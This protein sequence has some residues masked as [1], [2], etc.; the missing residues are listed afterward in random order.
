[1]KVF[2]RVIQGTIVCLAQHFAEPAQQSRRLAITCL[3]LLCRAFGHLPCSCN[4]S[5]QAWDTQKIAV[6]AGVFLDILRV[7][8]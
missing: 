4:A 2:Q 5:E 8:H 1:M 6:A 3:A 7:P